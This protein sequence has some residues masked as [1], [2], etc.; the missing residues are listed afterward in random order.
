MAAGCGSNRSEAAPSSRAPTI[1]V[2]PIAPSTLCMTR[3]TLD[4]RSITE[5]TVRGY[6]PGA[7]GDA[8]QLTF[9]YRGDSETT[10]ELASGEARRQIGL[11]LRAQ[12]GCNL[13]YVMWRLDPKPKLDVSVKYNPGKRNHAEC[14]AD[15]YTK[16]RPRAKR[17][18][19]AFGY[20][21][22]HTLR[23]EIVGDD[24]FAWID[25]Q[26]RFQ[27]HLPRTARTL[28]GPAG[29]RSDNV[30]FDLVELAA[31]HREGTPPA[32]KREQGD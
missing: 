23:A 11:K 26:L 17:F 12:D 32:C 10:R 13:V 1:D 30:K 2:A 20:G 3:G 31:P 24:L 14:G 16:V 9:T 8:A 19:P 22:T 18:V 28:S 27:G 6:A 15:G 29:L 25:G 7:G 5:P 21:K 4:R